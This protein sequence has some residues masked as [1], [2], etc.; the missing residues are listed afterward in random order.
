[1]IL[2]AAEPVVV[3]PFRTRIPKA[4]PAL[5]NIVQN[6]IVVAQLLDRYSVLGRCD[7]LQVA[8]QGIIVTNRHCTV[9]GS[10][11]TWACALINR[12]KFPENRP[13]RRGSHVAYRFQITPG[14]VLVFDAKAL[15]D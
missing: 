15:A 3:E 2:Q 14:I 7:H 6:V 8:C 5:P 4:I 11:L 13:V 12:L 10:L 1:M 9:P